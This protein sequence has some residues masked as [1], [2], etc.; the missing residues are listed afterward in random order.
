MYIA[1][2]RYANRTDS[3]LY[4]ADISA[5]YPVTNDLRV[6]PRVAFAYQEGN[7]TN[8]QEFS[9]LPSVLFNYAW[10]RDLNFEMEAGTKWTQRQQDTSKEN[11]TD[12]FFTLGVRYD[13]SADGR[14]DCAYFSPVCK[15]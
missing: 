3:N 11:Q 15:K 2:I 4:V 12:F 10:T 14:A 13:F 1:G 9:V 5:R 6:S 7:T 8:F